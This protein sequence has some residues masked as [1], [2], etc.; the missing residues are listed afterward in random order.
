MLKELTWGAARKEEQ[1]TAKDLKLQLV[2]AKMAQAFG[3]AERTSAELSRDKLSKAAGEAIAS[4]LEKDLKD[5]EGKDEQLRQAQVALSEA[6]SERVRV[7]VQASMEISS[8]RRQLKQANLLNNEMRSRGKADTGMKMGGS[9][10]QELVE[11]KHFL[12][13]KLAE[14]EKEICRQKC[15]NGHLP[16]G[17][18]PLLLSSSVPPLSPLSPNASTAGFRRLK[19]LIVSPAP[20]WGV[21]GD[22]SKDDSMTPSTPPPMSTS[23]SSFSSRRASLPPVSPFSNSNNQPTT[24]SARGRHTPKRRSSCPSFSS[25]FSSLEASQPGPPSSSSRDPGAVPEAPAGFHQRKGAML[26]SSSEKLA[27]R[28]V[29]AESAREQTLQP[30]VLSGRETH[31][32]AAALDAEADE[33]LGSLWEARP[34]DGG[35]RE[36]ARRMSEEGRCQVLSC[37]EKRVLSADDVATGSMHRSSS[38][39]KLRSSEDSGDSDSFGDHLNY[40]FRQVSAGGQQHSGTNDTPPCPASSDDTCG[41]EEVQSPFLPVICRQEVVDSPVASPAQ[42]H[43]RKVEEQKPEHQ[44]QQLHLPSPEVS[45]LTLPAISSISLQEG[46]RAGNGS[47]GGSRSS[48][49]GALSPSPTAAGPTHLEAERDIVG[50][51]RR[52]QHPSAHKRSAAGVGLAGSPSGS[53]PNSSGESSPT[54]PAG[55]GSLRVLPRMGRAPECKVPELLRGRGAMKGAAVGGGAAA[56]VAHRQKRGFTSGLSGLPAATGTA[57]AAPPSS[58]FPPARR[59]SPFSSASRTR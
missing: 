42:T 35:G 40:L 41:K 55:G 43:F 4:M 10:L 1:H 25:L 11:E 34:S 47:I 37:A 9:S 5:L 46:V 32:A 24:L 38:F 23:T 3:L 39:K 17:S 13:N 59:A 6:V 26:P 14:A 2:E 44:Q 16:A 31:G 33:R 50:S 12:L 51:R 48:S 29:E 57:A 58:G 28:P 45:T 21:T 19:C 30:L 22:N 20:A 18:T 53:S 49:E 27:R 36:C 56:A 52:K 8:L 54:Q 15:A 7:E